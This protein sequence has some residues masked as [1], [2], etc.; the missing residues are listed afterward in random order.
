MPDELYDRKALLA[1]KEQLSLLKLQIQTNLKGQPKQLIEDAIK[2]YE[3]AEAMLDTLLAASGENINQVAQQ[4]MEDYS[5]NTANLFAK[6]KKKLAKKE[7][8]ERRRHPEHFETGFAGFDVEL[9]TL[10]AFESALAQLVQGLH[11][12]NNFA[13]LSEKDRIKG[14]MEALIVSFFETDLLTVRFESYEL[15]LVYSSIVLF[16]ED[17]GGKLPRDFQRQ[18]FTA[19]YQKLLATPEQELFNTPELCDENGVPLWYTQIVRYFDN[20]QTPFGFDLLCE[21]IQ[22][23]SV[24][25]EKSPESLF[26][27]LGTAAAQRFDTWQELV[28]SL[29]FGLL[30]AVYLHNCTDEFSFAFQQTRCWLSNLFCCSDSPTPFKNKN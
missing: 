19:F 11:A 17:T 18:G 26:L 16:L 12:P 13:D 30:F 29:A 23:A 1:Q 15:D 28:E 10:E 21:A 3:A 5:A 22:F 2:Q 20:R 9:L 6:Q 27:H 4:A 8:K 25:S 7:A 24:E 14:T